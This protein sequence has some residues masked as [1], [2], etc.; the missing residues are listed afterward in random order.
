MKRSLSAKV[1]MVG[2]SLESPGGMTSVVKL[3]RDAGFFETWNVCYLNSYERP[4]VVL[5]L[6]VV[7]SALVKFLRLLIT[8][9][10]ALL[11]VHSA[12][13]GSFWR[14]S[15]F[16]AV[17]RAF[18]VPYIFHMH[19][20]EFPVF[21]RNECGFLARWWVSYTLR[22]ACC[23]IALTSSWRAELEIL[24]PGSK[25][26]VVGNPV[27]ISEAL[28]IRSEKPLNIL[29]LG[30]LREK[31]GVFDLVK[32]IPCVLESVPEAIFT[33][34]GDGDLEGVAKQAQILGVNHAV[35]LPGWV[36]GEAKDALLAAA[37]V[38]VLPSYFEGL[39]ICILEAMA[40]GVPVVSTA[41]GGIPEALENGTCGALVSPGD[42]EALACE[43][44]TCLLDRDTTEHVRKQ[45]FLRANNFY[46]V[47]TIMGSLGTLYRDSI[48]VL[49]AVIDDKGSMSEKNGMEKK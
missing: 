13:R 19:S 23:V 39:P 1:V 17:A 10:V 46:S 6:R 44:I 16:C 20:G 38:L 37:D 14:K 27:V 43:I 12:S 15:I 22:N 35:N 48:V 32:A 40:A 30:R 24:I 31:K 2:T 42:V 49:G 33:I 18:R 7:A 34:A 4:G 36:N 41:V 26:V 9:K 11:H 47:S 3:Y 8:G 21:V 28:S 25:V 5:Q 29:F 45:A